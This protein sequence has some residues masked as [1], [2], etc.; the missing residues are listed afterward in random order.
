MF[1]KIHKEEEELNDDE[2]ETA[3]PATPTLPISPS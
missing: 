2:P 1:K 3:I